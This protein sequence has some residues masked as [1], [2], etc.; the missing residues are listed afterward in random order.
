[1]IY[2][3]FEVKNF[4]VQST[5]NIH[6]LQGKIYIPDGEIKGLF[7]IV[8]GMQEYIGRYDALMSA[9]AENGYLCFGH[10]HLGHGHTAKDGSELGFFAYNNGWK[11]LVNDVFAFAEAV[12]KIYP[13]KPLH[14][15]GHSMGSF[16]VRLA[17]ESYPQAYKKLIICGTGGKN[18]LA[19]AGLLITDI[20]GLL[21]GK[22]HISKA[23]NFMV[24][25]SYNS[26]FEKRTG[27]DWL[28]KDITVLEKYKD[29]PFCRF[30]FTVC[31]MH[32]LIK[33]NV[34]CNRKK[35]FE[36]INPDMPI[37]LI[38]GENDPVGNYGKGV[39][40]VYR[41]LCRRS[42]CVC[43][44]LYENCRHEILNDDSRAQVL[45]DIFDFLKK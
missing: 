14:L 20:I 6:T 33:L 27:V 25:G 36:E 23:V 5:D 8:H 13:D 22:K 44:K 40:Q 4:S 45:F 31:A 39:K 29:D 28:T 12:K 19:P 35:W 30:K 7:Q 1:M 11:Y 9:A 16:I 10:D 38:S 41:G 32:D 17:A 42:T 2:T 34:M 43:M 24:F 3:S 21:F 26:R 37:L 15:F 18:P